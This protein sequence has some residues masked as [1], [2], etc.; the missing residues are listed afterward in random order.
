MNPTRLGWIINRF[1]GEIEIVDP[2]GEVRLRRNHYGGWRTSTPNEPDQAWLEE[3]RDVLAERVLQDYLGWL[4]RQIAEMPFDR[5][6]P[7]APIVATE[8]DPNRTVYHDALGREVARHFPSSGKLICSPGATIGGP[9]LFH[10]PLPFLQ[11][12]RCFGAFHPPFKMSSDP[13]EIVIVDQVGRTALTVGLGGWTPSQVPKMNEATWLEHCRHISPAASPQEAL[14]HLNR[15]RLPLELL[16]VASEPLLLTS[17]PPRLSGKEGPDLAIWAP[18]LQR[19]LPLCWHGQTLE[20][21]WEFQRLLGPATATDPSPN[22]ILQSLRPWWRSAKVALPGLWG[23]FR[24]QD[25][26]EGKQIVDQRGFPIAHYSPKTYRFALW[27]YVGG[28][29]DET[30]RYRHLREWWKMQGLDGVT[31]E[32]QL[33]FLNKTWTKM[34]PQSEPKEEEMEDVVEPE[35]E[36]EAP[37]APEAP[38][39]PDEDDVASPLRPSL[40]IRRKLKAPFRSGD[41]AFQSLVFDARD[42][43]V[44]L[45]TNGDW[46]FMAP[47]HH[48]LTSWF[49]SLEADL[50]AYRLALALTDA[51]ESPP[52]DYPVALN[53]PFDIVGNNIVDRDGRCVAIFFEGRVQPPRAD[54]TAEID[55]WWEAWGPQDLVVA[56]KGLNEFWRQQWRARD[57]AALAEVFPDARL[58]DSLA[59]GYHRISFRA[60][61]V[62][63]FDL[64]VYPDG[65]CT[66][67]GEPYETV[68][69]A[70]EALK[71]HV[72]AI[73]SALTAIAS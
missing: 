11:S 32:S 51:W 54:A 19:W 73:L 3:R 14:D 47:A 69:L 59:H 24:V 57:L 40:S 18:Q 33:D 45:Q 44:A 34:V 5:L 37:P 70:A 10:D 13:L 1:A 68:R 67:F 48:E 25:S 64:K 72:Q 35:P 62:E 15:V 12:P 16:K 53:G 28:E 46:T 56:Q 4:C 58:L 60:G 2:T 21:L 63:M 49:N 6:P 66:L 41:N 29:R 42:V 39:E 9:E 26:P 27:G 8:R 65:T 71:H 38:P 17:W 50:D 20:A 30:L 52:R 7:V 23:P 22:E 43:L 36:A 31:P 55:N 61:E